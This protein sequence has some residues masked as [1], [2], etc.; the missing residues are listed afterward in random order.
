MVDIPNIELLMRFKTYLPMA[1]HKAEAYFG[2]FL[3]F[4]LMTD[5]CVEV[6]LRVYLADWTVFKD[7]QEIAN[8]FG[9]PDAWPEVMEQLSKG[10]FCDIDILGPERLQLH[11]QDDFRVIVS[12]N[13]ECYAP[14]D[15]LVVIYSKTF[16]V[17]GYSPAKGFQGEF[18]P[19]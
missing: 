10:L 5:E 1:V 16:I 8:S 6:N 3:R 18:R 9:N 13:L 19:A 14:E 4:S 17:L 2:T 11:F 15:E 7:K 12:A